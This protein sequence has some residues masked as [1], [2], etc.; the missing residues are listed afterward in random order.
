MFFERLYLK[1][2]GYISFL[3]EGGRAAEAFQSTL[4]GRF[5][6]GMVRMGAEVTQ[7]SPYLWCETITM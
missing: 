5:G 7:N 6:M 1:G 3:L 2:K 4:T